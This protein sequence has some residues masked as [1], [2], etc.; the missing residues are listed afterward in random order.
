[1]P[2]IAVRSRTFCIYSA[3]ISTRRTCAP[4]GNCC[5]SSP[6]SR[7][8][9][10]SPRPRRR[11]HRERAVR[12]MVR[13]LVFEVRRELL[14]R[15]IADCPQ[16]FHVRPRPVTHRREV[17]RRDVEGE[18]LQVVDLVALAFEGLTAAEILVE[19]REAR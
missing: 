18:R 19:S 10:A 16:P 4:R 2:P 6:D 13:Q 3:T 7:C 11:S 15:F 5:S 14:S 12:L 1:M 17:A 8:R 9:G